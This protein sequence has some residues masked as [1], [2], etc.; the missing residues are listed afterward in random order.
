MGYHHDGLHVVTN[1]RVT[2][3]SALAELRAQKIQECAGVNGAVPDLRRVKD[4]KDGESVPSLVVRAFGR[5]SS[6]TLNALH[7]VPLGYCFNVRVSRQGIG[8]KAVTVIFLQRLPVG[9]E[10]GFHALDHQMDVRL[11]HRVGP[12]ISAS[13]VRAGAIAGGN[14]ILSIDQEDWHDIVIVLEGTAEVFVGFITA[15]TSGN[16]RT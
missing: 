16:S 8:P 9:E 6:G 11:R 5:V 1:A 15:A 4:S 12:A 13:Q 7:H 10:P 3:G 14:G 2:R